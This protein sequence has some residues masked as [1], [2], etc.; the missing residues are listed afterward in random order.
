L[1]TG[2]LDIKI[3]LRSDLV[4]NLTANTDFADSDVD[5]QF[6]LTPYK[7]FFPEKRQFFLENAGVFGFPMGGSGDQLFFSRQIGID[8]ITGQQ[9]PINGEAKVTGSLGGFE[10]GVMDVDTRSS[11]P[12]PWTNSAVVRAKRS[13]WGSGSYIGFMGIDRRSGDVGAN[14]NQTSSVDGRFVLFKNLV[15]HGYASQTRTPGLASGQSNLGAGLTFRSNRL[16][17][18][19][20]HRKIGPNFNPEVGFLERADCICDYA[21]CPYRKLD[22]NKKG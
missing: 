1:H 6:N 15:L 8:P 20:E 4:A 3:G 7:L 21:D 13:L 12:N 19:A 18:F 16:D 22:L 11:G 10:V 5:V 2:G 17:F 9:D 14:F